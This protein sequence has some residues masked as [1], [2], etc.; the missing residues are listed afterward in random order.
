LRTKR[1]PE[2]FSRLAKELLEELERKEAVLAAAPRRPTL[3][4]PA[5]EGFSGLIISN[6]RLIRE[7]N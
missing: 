4:S 7:N 5:F 2:R 6:K 1:D 3:T